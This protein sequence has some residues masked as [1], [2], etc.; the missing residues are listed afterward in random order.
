MGKVSPLFYFNNEGDNTY[1]L[2]LC[3]LPFVNALWCKIT[4]WKQLRVH[5]TSKFAVWVHL[6]PYPVKLLFPLWELADSL[7][8]VLLY[9]PSSSFLHQHPPFCGYRRLPRDP[10]LTEANFIWHLLKSF[11]F[12]SFRKGKCPTGH[13][14]L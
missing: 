11:S 14:L 9:P 6:L 7:G 5:S 13:I 3:V 12:T 8:P 4:Q 10:R 2:L 1:L